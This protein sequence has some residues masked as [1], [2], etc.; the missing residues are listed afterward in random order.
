MTP[1]CKPYVICLTTLAV[2]ALMT[3]CAHLPSVGPNFKKP[4]APKDSGYAP[5]PLPAQTSSATNAAG[6]AAQ[7]FLSGQD[8]PF[9]WWKSFDCPQLNTLVEKALRQND[10]ITAAW[11]AVRQAQ[12]FVKA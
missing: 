10:S 8:I 7:R 9:D 11:A 6:G 1:P 4:D 5:G 12:E 3:S 2:S